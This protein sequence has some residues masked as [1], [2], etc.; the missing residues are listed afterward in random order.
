MIK[1]L[2][3]IFMCATLQAETI[4][5]LPYA[6]SGNEVVFDISRHRDT[7]HKIRKRDHYVYLE[8]DDITPIIQLKGFNI[9]IGT[10]SS[11]DRCRALLHITVQEFYKKKT[12]AL[13]TSSTCE[14]PKLIIEVEK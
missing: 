3:A 9:S 5:I 10:S 13:V 1:Y 8:S 14:N 6:T 12:L 7:L 4:T 2:T 11:K